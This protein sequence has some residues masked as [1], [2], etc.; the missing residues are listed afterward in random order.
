MRKSDRVQAA[1]IERLKRSHGHLGP[2]VS[3]GRVAPNLP[4]WR[5]GWQLEAGGQMCGRCKEWFE[6][7]P[8]GAA[9]RLGG[10]W[11]LQRTG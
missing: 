8:I 10:G 3:C 7:Q 2:C 1:Y 5:A 11:C 9:V 4:M 6:A